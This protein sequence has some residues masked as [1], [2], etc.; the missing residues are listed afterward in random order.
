M[1]HTERYSKKE[2]PPVT[3]R[4][5]LEAAIAVRSG[6]AGSGSTLTVTHSPLTMVS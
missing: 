1:F 2:K 5:E 4:R 3:H 6:Y